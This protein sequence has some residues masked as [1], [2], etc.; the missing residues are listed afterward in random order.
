MT[1]NFINTLVDNK[2]YDNQELLPY[3]SFIGD[4]Y[5][6]WIGHNKDGST[7]EVPGQWHFSWILKGKAIQDNWICPRIDLKNNGIYPEGEFGTTIRFFDKIEKKIKIIWIGPEFSNLNI[8]YAKIEDNRIIQVEDQKKIE[9]NKWIFS[10]IKKKSFKWEAYKSQDFGR[11]WF[12]E[13]E[14]Y[15]EKII[16]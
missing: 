5:F 14:L 10:D 3:A 15:S 9:Q 7:W 6:Q 12:L 11:N 2:T 1:Y 16:T 4:W 8:F 13:Q